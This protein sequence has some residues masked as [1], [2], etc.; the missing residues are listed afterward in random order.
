M[1]SPSAPIRAIRSLSPPRLYPHLPRTVRAILLE[2]NIPA[3]D[4]HETAR[5]IDTA[6]RVCDALAAHADPTDLFTRALFQQA[7][8]QLHHLSKP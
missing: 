8:Q 4:T 7:A 3:A 1:N 6:A 2:H 5:A